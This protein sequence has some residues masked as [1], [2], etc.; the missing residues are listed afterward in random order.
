[1]PRLLLDLRMFENTLSCFSFGENLH[2]SL[3]QESDLAMDDLGRY[4]T[5]KG[6][7]D[8]Y[9][10]PQVPTIEDCFIRLLR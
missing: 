1:M 2:L 8:V 3:K 9:I 10:R 5:M 6:H 7:N 4:V